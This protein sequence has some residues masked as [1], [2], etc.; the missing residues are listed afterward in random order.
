MGQLPGPEDK[1]VST[2]RILGTTDLH[3]H[4]SSHDF[5]RDTAEP[6]VGLTRVASLIRAARAEVGATNCLLFDNGDGLQGTPMEE[7]PEE[8]AHPLM[9]CFQAL[10]YDAIGLGNHDFDFGPE[11]LARVLDQA[12]C[13]VICSNLIWEDSPT[14]WPAKAM[15]LLERWIAG[16]D[17]TARKMRVGVFSVLPPQTLKWNGQS[18]GHRARMAGIVDCAMQSIAV[19]RKRGAD[20]V[21]ALALS[22]LGPELA[23]PDTEN[24][25]RALTRLQGLDAIIAGHSHLPFA[26]HGRADQAVPLVLPGF[27]GSHLGVIDLELRWDN[28]AGWQVTGSTAALRA[29]SGPSES[30]A[31]RS[32]APE[33]AA[34]TA[35]LSPAISTTQ[36]RMEESVGHTERWAVTV[37]HRH[38]PRCFAVMPCTAIHCRLR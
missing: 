25:A 23:E 14:G 7:V 26:H 13:P 31:Q 29:I 8:S 37:S 16:P 9:Q 28:A 3:M 33:D 15:T 34:L 21:I 5:F 20:I 22:G 11:T 38:R 12:P 6:A 2:L 30:G 1:G 27:A 24:A 17:G 36:A 18:L 4:L 10:G 35:I 19:L 32:L